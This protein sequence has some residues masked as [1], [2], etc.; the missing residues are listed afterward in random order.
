M[1]PLAKTLAVVA[2]IAA[3]LTLVLFVGAYT[4]LPALVEGMVARNLKSNLGLSRTPEVELTADPAYEI[5]AGNF[6]SGEVVLTEP[7]F[8]GVRP[9]QVRMDL[10]GFEVDLAQSMREGGLR[11][12][13]PLTGEIRVVLS[14]GELERIASTGIESV[15]VREIGISDG[16]LTVGSSTEVL[17]V[18]VP[19][20]V[21]GPVSVEEGRIVYAPEEAAAFGTPLPA[22]VTDR[23]LSGTNFGYPVEDLPFN[24]EVTGIETGEGTLALE[25]SVRDLPVS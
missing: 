7:E 10:D 12:D 14:E 19:V 18:D 13:E 24:G 1:R 16:A 9:E 11:V 3:L 5:L 2:V 21:S 25:G 17:G 23:I 4:F 20:S 22:D 6:D 8:A 15:P